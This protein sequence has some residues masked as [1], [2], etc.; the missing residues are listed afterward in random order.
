MILFWY[1]VGVLVSFVVSIGLN[2]LIKKSDSFKKFYGLNSNR[3]TLHDKDIAIYSLMSWVW[4][5]IVIWALV[6][7]AIVRVVQIIKGEYK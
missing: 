4:V 6:A 7:D 1:S 3:N 5:T 2:H